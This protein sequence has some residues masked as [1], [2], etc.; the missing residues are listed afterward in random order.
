MVS[1]FKMIGMPLYVGTVRLKKLTKKYN[2]RV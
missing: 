1:K 2:K